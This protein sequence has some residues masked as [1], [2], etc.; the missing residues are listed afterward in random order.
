MLAST[1][2]S[3]ISTVVVPLIVGLVGGVFGGLLTRVTSRN[4]VR[5]D[6]YAEALAALSTLQSLA[7]NDPVRPEAEAKVADLAAWLELDSLPVGA[8]FK[9]LLAADGESAQRARENY[10]AAARTFSRWTLP[11][12]SLLHV[13]ALLGRRG[14]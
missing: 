7:P 5:R 8:A 14:R 11:Q 6:K 12:R 10:I 13:K 1:T 9:E 3:P 4:D 2:A